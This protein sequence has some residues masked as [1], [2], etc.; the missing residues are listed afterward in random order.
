DNVPF[1]QASFYGDW[2]KELGRAVKR[3]LVY[4]DGEIVAYFQLIKYPLLFGKSYLYIPYGPVVRSV[5]RDFFVALKQKLKRIAKIEK[6][7]F[8]SEK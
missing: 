2:Q 4:S 6:A 8:V 7:I 5:A 3:F 1:T